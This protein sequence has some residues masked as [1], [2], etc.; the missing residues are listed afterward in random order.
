MRA[1]EYRAFTPGRHLVVLARIHGNEGC[2]ADGTER[3]MREIDSGELTLSG[4][5]LTLVPCCNP[6]AKNLNQRF[7]D[8]NLNRVFRHSRSPKSYEEHLA[9]NLIAMIGKPDFLLDLHSFHT[10]GKRPVTFAVRAGRDQLTGHVKARLPV[11]FCLNGWREVQSAFGRPESF[12]TIDH[13]QEIGV[14]AIG[15]ECGQHEAASSKR[16]AY[17][18]IRE[19][20]AELGICD[21]GPTKRRNKIPSDVV[22]K[23]L[24]PYEKGATFSKVWRE[25]DP[26]KKGAVIGRLASGEPVLAPVAGRMLFPHPNAVPGEEW[27]YIAE[28]AKP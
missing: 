3:I 18:C 22:F 4:G 11:D 6:S 20:M 10:S 13:A 7:I 8:K 16:V 14:P 23:Y 26:V 24:R 21:L 28:E 2:G 5:R 12:S 19:V 25:F 27:F 15:V 9:N 17:G 1:V